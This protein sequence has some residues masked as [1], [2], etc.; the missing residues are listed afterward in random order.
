MPLTAIEHIILQKAAVDGGFTIEQPPEN[1]WLAYESLGTPVRLWLTVC[2]NGYAVATDHRGVVEELSGR[3]RPYPGAVPSN[4]TGFLAAGTTDLQN[5]VVD[6]WRLGRALP[7]APL[8]MF[9]VQTK[10]MLRTTEAERLVVQRVGQDVFRAALMD[11]WGKT[12]AVTG[13]TEPCV[14]R[15]SHIKPWARCDT[16]AERLDVFNGLLLAAH[17]DAAFD[18]G[19]ISFASAGGLIVSPS[20]RD[21]DRKALGIHEGLRLR[22]VPEPLAAHLAWHREYVFQRD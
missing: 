11:Y 2:P 22:K 18:A 16:D 3:W 8:R 15:A 13:V 12:C 17:L 5:I 14:L 10:D 20:F 4:C 1:D 7:I 6:V 19:L 21:H 9:E